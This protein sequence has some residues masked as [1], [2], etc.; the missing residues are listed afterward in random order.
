M[1]GRKS[2]T[3]STGCARSSMFDGSEDRCSRVR[4]DVRKE[5]P[6]VL[7]LDRGGAARRRRSR[8]PNSKADAREPRPRSKHR[9]PIR[10]RSR[11]ARSRRHG[12]PYTRR[13]PALRADARRGDR[14]D[15]ARDAGRR[16]A[17]PRR[18]STARAPPNSRS[19]ATSMPQRS[20]PLVTSS[21]ATGRAR[22]RTRACRCRSCPTS[23]PSSSFET[24]DK[25]NAYLM[26]R[27]A[28]PLNDTAPGLSGDAASR[29][30]VLGDVAI[31]AVCGNGCGRRRG[32]R[33][34]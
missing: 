25:A 31:V 27:A 16:E 9:A 33:M 20:R 11:S 1:A 29:I 10:E 24:P 32:C 26:R 2:R 12:N 15:H 28:M 18:S 22:R 7:R 17:I 19:S 30:Y 5:L 6:D 8:R 14:A 21:S 4:T 23:P 13:R 3:R 34:E